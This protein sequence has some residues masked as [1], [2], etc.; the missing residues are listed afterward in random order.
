MAARPR[1]RA[2]LSADT[3]SPLELACGTPFDGEVASLPEAEGTPVEALE[4]AVLEA[5]AGGAPVYVAYSGGRDSALVLAAAVAAARR[6]GL[7]QPV[8]LTVRL[9]GVPSAQEDDWQERTVAHLGLRDWQKVVVTDELDLLGPLAREVLERHGLYWPANAHFIAFLLRRV[10]GG[11]LLTGDGGDDLF[12]WWRWQRA[13][14]LLARRARGRPRDAATVAVALGP[15]W[16]RRRAAARRQGDA[17]RLPWLTP[18][19]RGEYATAL[20]RA[21]EVPRRWDRHLAWVAGRRAVTVATAVLE[22]MAEDAG[23]HVGS[24]LLAP[25]FLAARALF[26]DLLPD[27]VLGRRDKASFGPVF[28]GAASRR[29]AEAWDGIGVDTAIVDPKALRS[30]WLAENPHWQSSNLIHHCWLASSA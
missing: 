25:G 27:D 19:A 21:A 4:Q 1:G 8:P 14:D 12:D 9:P 15:A 23:A 17:A 26:G 29:F 11:T 22:R 18:R 10:E 24:P 30:T 6:H 5:M 3:L 16:L 7:P 13:A 2:P 20:T 28:F